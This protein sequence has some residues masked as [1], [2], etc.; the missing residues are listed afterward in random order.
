MAEYNGNPTAPRTQGGLLKQDAKF[1]A[2]AIALLLRQL[3]LPSLFDTH[4]EGEF[5]GA[6]GDTV[7]IKRP[8]VLKSYKRDMRT[9]PNGGT[10]KYKRNVLNEWSIPVRL[11]T[12]LYTAINLSDAMMTLDVTSF[13]TQVIDPQIRALA[14][15]YE[16]E[17]AAAM[18]TKFA[19]NPKSA[20]LALD[21]SKITDI[22]QQAAAIRRHLARVRKAFN[23]ENIPSNGRVI[24]LGSLLESILLTDPHLTRMDEAGTTS[25]LTEA[26]LGRLYGFTLV[27]SNAVAED[28]FFAFHGS[29]LQLITMA[30]ANPAGAPF[31]SSLSANGVALR[32]IRD[33]DFEVATDRSLINTYMGIGEVLDVPAA[34]M[35]N[36]D[37]TS[38]VDLQAQAKQLRGFSIAV[39]FPKAT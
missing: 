29:A 28:A 39:T 9:N 32:Y 6:L 35:K 3:V 33:Y 14:E 16:D 36:L 5:S 24:V 26:V 18:A 19:A 34:V 7:N 10:D 12:N 22:E 21:L 31:S 25:A 8:S 4:A 30:P 37:T 15:Q 20:S 1:A 2:T 17:V 23:D 27:S 38:Y 13:A 11:D